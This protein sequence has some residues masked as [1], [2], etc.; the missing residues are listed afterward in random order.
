M[1]KINQKEQR[2]IELFLKKGKMSSS[3]AYSELAGLGEEISLVTVK[4][5]L[6]KMAVK[7]LLKVHGSGRATSYDISTL[8]RM[9]ADIVA[10]DYCAT[11]PDRRYGMSSFNFEFFPTLPGEIFADK[12]LKTLNSA[13]LE[14]KRK[15]TNLP[16]TIQKKELERL[17]IEL[18]WKSSKIEGN[19]YTLLDTE[20]LILENKEAPGHDKKEAIMILNHKDAFNFIHK[21]KALF[22]TFNRANLEKL[23]AILVKNLSVGLGFRKRLV[24]VVGSKYRPLDNIHQIEEAASQ[25]FLAVARVESIY[26]KALIALLGISYIQPFEDGNK[27]TSRLMA[28][29][30]LFAHGLAPLSYRSVE[31]KEYREATL[32]FYELNSIVPLRNIFVDQYNFAAN[33]YVVK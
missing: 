31:E 30:L 13:T 22:K 19:T 25:L 6:S 23:H 26:A 4:R 12:D 10:R 5:I 18:S 15:T 20:K 27:R 8:G 21:N 3:T 1:L 28:N 33:N 14:Y 11:E 32:V 7:S 2:I 9:F 17:I 29:A 24:G 16:R